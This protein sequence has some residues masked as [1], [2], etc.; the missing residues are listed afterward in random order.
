MNSTVSDIMKFA[1]NNYVSYFGQNIREIMYKY[2]ID[3]M[4]VCNNLGFIIQS[5]YRHYNANVKETD[6]ITAK[7]IRELISVREHKFTVTHFNVFD[8][9]ALL[10]YLCIS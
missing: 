10:N 4:N 2:K 7:V 6:R 8:V 5:I 1:V 3:Q 9:S